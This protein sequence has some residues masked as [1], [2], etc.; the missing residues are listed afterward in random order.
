MLSA[1]A[2]RGWAWHQQILQ[3]RG[4][5]QGVTRSVVCRG[6]CVS[7]PKP[8]ASPFLLL[9]T[10]SQCDYSVQLSSST[11]EVSDDDDVSS[12]AC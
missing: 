11:N 3:A 4:V 12:V 2:A 5:A 8:P 10:M 7:A 6:G 1:R 9:Y